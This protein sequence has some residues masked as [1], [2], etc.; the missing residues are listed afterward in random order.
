LGEEVV[1]PSIR[2][3]KQR[4]EVVEMVKRCCIIVLLLGITLLA[5]VPA[6]GMAQDRYRSRA[7]PIFHGACSFVIPGCGQY[8]NGERGKAFSHF[9]VALLIPSACYM[10]SRISPYID[11]YVLYP[12]CGLLSL[13][14]HVYSAVD[15]FETAERLNEEGKFALYVPTP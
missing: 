4:E 2:L 15:A 10:V 8:L 14:W 5:F 9:L 6:T 12:V 7:E 13:G 1:Q 3:D 11:Y